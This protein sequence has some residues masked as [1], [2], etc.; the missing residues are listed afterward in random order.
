M[1]EERLAAQ[2]RGE[3]SSGM[4]NSPQED[5]AKKVPWEG[6]HH[7]LR[8]ETRFSPKDKQSWWKAC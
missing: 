6:E 4:Q 3:K 7:A 8:R 1:P 5:R 2:K